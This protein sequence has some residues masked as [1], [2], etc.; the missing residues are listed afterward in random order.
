M[1]RR[2]RSP[3]STVR[4]MSRTI[5]SPSSSRPWMNS[6]RG[7][8]GT[9]RR[10]SRMPTARIGAQPE[11]EPPAHAGSIDR[12][13]EQRDR[14]QRAG[15]RADPERAVDR[16]V[17]A[18]AVLLR[19]QLVDGGVDGGVLA[20]DAGAGEEAARRSTTSAFIE[21]AVST[22]GDRV[23]AEREHEQLL[24]AEPVG[25]LA[26]EQGADAGAGDVDRAGQADVGAAEPEAGA[27]GLERRRTW[28]RR[29]SP[30]ARR[31]STP[32]PGR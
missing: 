20:A 23:D 16:D 2:R 3:P 24:A 19:D 1:Q 5:R 22:V 21:N 14:Q 8:S 17:D 18:A 15:G 26:E 7:L 10:T 31:G 12:R 28:S 11:R 29:S 9:L 25:E 30:R 4:S 6:Q 27:L 32:C 13:V